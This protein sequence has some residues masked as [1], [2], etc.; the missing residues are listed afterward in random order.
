MRFDIPNH[1]R[2]ASPI[3]RS[4]RLPGFGAI[5]SKREFISSGRWRFFNATAPTT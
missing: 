4:E 3:V 2:Q 5:M 1:Q